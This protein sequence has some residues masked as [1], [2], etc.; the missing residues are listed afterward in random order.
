MSSQDSSSQPAS[1]TGGTPTG[2]RPTGLS[3]TNPSR[4]LSVLSSP[5]QELQSTA[6]SA[7]T[8]QPQEGEPSFSTTAPTRP[9][10]Q[11]RRTIPRDGSPGDRCPSQERSSNPEGGRPHPV[12]QLRQPSAATRQVGASID[13]GEEP[14]DGETLGSSDSTRSEDTPVEGEHDEE[15]IEVAVARALIRLI[16]S[17]APTPPAAPYRY[18]TRWQPTA[19]RALWGN[20]Y[21]TRGG[22]GRRTEPVGRLLQALRST[23]ARGRRSG[24]R[25]TR[26]YGGWYSRK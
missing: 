9:S 20:A 5:R 13:D 2:T 24:P 1:S 15:K 17:T 11:Q 10:R 26:P 6:T 3:R 4:F 16:N 21:T 23:P 14:A 12:L 8:S 18:T 7:G 22:Y 19:R 25:S